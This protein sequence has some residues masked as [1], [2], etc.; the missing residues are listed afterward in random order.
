MSSTLALPGYFVLFALIHSLL[1]D[2]GMKAFM[3]A[4]YPSS[5]RWY[6][7][8][9]VLLAWIMVLP[10][11]YL[12]ILHPGRT[13]YSVPWPGN[14]IMRA[15][16]GLAALGLLFSLKQTGISQFLG[17]GQLRSEGGAEKLVTDGIYCHLRNPLFLFGSLFLWLS[18]SMTLSLLAFNIL[19]TAYFYL[20]ARHEER[21]LGKEFGKPYEE[22]RR[23]VPMFLPHLRCR[24]H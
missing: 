13:L 6:R 14:W 24:A 12:I 23:S 8:A 9:Y 22:Y 3:R 11:L 5:E 7:L 17:L 19:T 1:A 21:S 16:Q 10:F 20:G 15:G 2:P 18:P 4:I